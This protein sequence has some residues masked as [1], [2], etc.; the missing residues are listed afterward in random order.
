[1]KILIIKNQ[2]KSYTCEYDLENRRATSSTNPRQM[3]GTAC[4][5]SIYCNNS[6]IGVIAAWDGG[7]LSQ[8]SPLDVREIIR[9]SDSTGEM[10]NLS[11]M[12]Y[13]FGKRERLIEE[14]PSAAEFIKAL[15]P[16]DEGIECN[17]RWFSENYIQVVA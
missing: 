2:N 14:T 3:T 13:A 16:S 8:S 17:F 1:M 15:Y 6:L 11:A 9:A 12:I 10:R 7:T 5:V 4:N